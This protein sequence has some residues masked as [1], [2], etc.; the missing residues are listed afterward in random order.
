MTYTQ[1]DRERFMTY[2]DTS[3]SLSDCWTWTGR[4]KKGGYGAFKHKGKVLS[5]HRVM[6]EMCEG[7]VQPNSVIRH[8]CHVPN[9]V[10]I[11][12]LE[13]GTSRENEDL[14]S[15]KMNC[16]CGK[17]LEVAWGFCPMCG[18]VVKPEPSAVERARATFEVAKSAANKREAWLYKSCEL[19]EQALQETREAA[20]VEGAKVVWNM[21]EIA[22]GYTWADVEE[23]LERLKA[24][25]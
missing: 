9:C 12:H 16:P 1:D 8:K 6:Y 19:Y 20:L 10:R 15:C 14:E 7:S 23:A 13:T 21:F 17:E 18:E 25:C 22:D 24:G 4:T 2:V 3:E 11:D 5:A